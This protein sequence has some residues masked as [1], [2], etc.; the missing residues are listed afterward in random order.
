MPISRAVDDAH[1]VDED[2]AILGGH[3]LGEARWKP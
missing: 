2:R 1:V 3:E